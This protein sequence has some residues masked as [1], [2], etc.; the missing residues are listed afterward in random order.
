MT[1]LFDWMNPPSP[2]T[3]SAPH[4]SGERLPCSDAA[5]VGGDTN[6]GSHLS[7]GGSLTDHMICVCGKIEMD[8]V[9]CRFGASHQALR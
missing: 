4:N 6:G 3:F 7:R 5:E 8:G 2:P 1:D 9:R